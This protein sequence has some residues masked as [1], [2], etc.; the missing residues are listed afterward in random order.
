MRR[1]A[2][3]VLG[4]GRDLR[5]LRQRDLRAGEG[6]GGGLRDDRGTRGL[7]ARGR[8]VSPDRVVRSTMAPVRTEGEPRLRRA[9]PGLRTW[10]GSTGAG[11]GRL[12]L[13][14][15]EVGA[16]G[17]PSVIAGRARQSLPG[18]FRRS[19][20]PPPAPATALREGRRPPDA[21]LAARPH[22]LAARGRARRCAARRGAA[23]LGR[24]GGA[25]RR[26][27]AAADDRAAARRPRERRRPVEDRGL[28]VTGFADH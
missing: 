26:L 14:R 1:R 25:G 20:E 23:D 12:Q 9:K 21:G 24:I 4:G 10:S 7:R 15:A 17:R 28:G 8:S 16:A 5:W 3:R 13:Q 11:A 18:E 2:R 27:A 19:R 22:A 6:D